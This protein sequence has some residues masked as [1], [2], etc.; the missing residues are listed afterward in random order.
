MCTAATGLEVSSAETPGK[1]AMLRT[2]RKKDDYDAREMLMKADAGTGWQRKSV[3][4]G[5]AEMG[6]GT[7]TV[8]AC[9]PFSGSIPDQEANQQNQK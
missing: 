7:S 3:L 1:W 6:L 2:A 9:V 8:G 4:V 5:S